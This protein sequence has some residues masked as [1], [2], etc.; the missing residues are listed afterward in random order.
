MNNGDFL[1]STQ[2]GELKGVLNESFRAGSG[3]DLKRF[4]DSWVNFVFDSGEFT[5]SVFPDDSNV[6]VVM[7]VGDGWERVAKV[8]IGVMIEM[9]VEF[10]VV[11]VLG[12]DAFFWDHDTHQDAFIFLEKGSVGGI[13]KGEILEG[14]E[15]NR[16]VGCLE[17]IKD[18]V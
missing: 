15:L 17:Y 5:F 11:I 7:F 18:R 12:N 14:V 16:N 2:V 10:V 8:D 9:F 6:N 1:S 3:G 4:H 13:L